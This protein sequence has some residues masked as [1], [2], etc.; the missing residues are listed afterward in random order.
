M[1]IGRL[2]NKIFQKTLTLRSTTS[3]TLVVNDDKYLITSQQPLQAVHSQ[4]HFPR[5]GNDSQKKAKLVIW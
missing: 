3:D 5:L 2:L 4:Q 1:I